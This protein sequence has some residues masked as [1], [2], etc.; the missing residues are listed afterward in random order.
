[1]G[2]P[3]KWLL[4]SS[5]ERLKLYLLINEKRKKMDV[6]QGDYYFF[7]RDTKLVTAD[8]LNDRDA[9]EDARRKKT[10]LIKFTFDDGHVVR[11]RTLY[12]PE[13][14]LPFF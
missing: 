7:E 3:R 10:A 13:R 1:M 5:S 9:I 6:L 8:Q 2:A 4:D 11:R 14:A 12:D